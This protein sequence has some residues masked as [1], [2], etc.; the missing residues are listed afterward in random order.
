MT[1]DQETLKQLIHY[2]PETGV[3]TWLVQR[4]GGIKPGDRAGFVSKG[5]G[6]GYLHIKVLARKYQASRLAWLYMTGEW[7]E[8]LVDHRD[9][10]RANNKWSNL[11]HATM[12]QNC[13]NRKIDPRNMLGVKGVSK[14]GSK[15][16]ARITVEGK[17][18]QIGAF[19]TI[20]DA[21]E[22]YAAAAAA[23]YGEFARPV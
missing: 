5:E 14:C 19:S 3:F 10:D 2:C 16:R 4:G 17:L 1:L 23:T 15:F 20:E 13:A 11:R 7:P 6:R 12:V 21:A 22:A 9:R 8:D 18:Q